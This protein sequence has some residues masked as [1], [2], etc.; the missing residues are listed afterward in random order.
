M[1]V[2]DR[3]TPRQSW[4]KVQ[5][6]NRKLPF[7]LK[8][9]DSKQFVGMGLEI[10]RTARDFHDDGSIPFSRPAPVRTSNV[11]SSSMIPI[12]SRVR[13]TAGEHEASAVRHYS[14]DGERKAVVRGFY[15]CSK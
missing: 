1:A 8:G 7:A 5:T 2:T 3:I 15:C 11:R 6:F 10:T 12:G 9:R 14:A 13:Q 4:P